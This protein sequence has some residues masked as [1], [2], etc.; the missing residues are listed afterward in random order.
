MIRSLPLVQPSR[1]FIFG[2][3]L[4]PLSKR[5]KSNPMGGREKLLQPW[6]K[7]SRPGREY[8]EGI[9]GTS[10]KKLHPRGGIPEP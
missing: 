8:S 10:Y 4:S 1:A 2:E 9:P 6:N 3:F 7:K 5:L